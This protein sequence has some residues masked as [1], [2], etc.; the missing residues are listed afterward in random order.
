M[1]ILL[2]G[3]QGQLGWELQRCLAPLGEY[4]A[5][6]FPRVDLGQPDSLRGLLRALCPEVIV[7]AAAYT[8]VDRAEQ[9]PEQAF[10]VNAAA[11]GVL[12][13]E[14]ARLRAVLIHYS[15][16]YVFDGQKG[17]PYTEEEAPNPLNVYG[18]SKWAGEQAVQNAGGA[19]LI[20]R[21]SWVYSLQRDS[22]VTKVLGWARKQQTMRVVTD[23]VAN[24]TWARMLAEL[25][26]QLLAQG[27]K[28]LH[29]WCFE[30]R[31]IYHAA[32]S[33]FTSRYEWGKAVLELDPRREEQ[34]VREYLPAL[35]ADYP[36]PA[37]RPL[38]SALDC[39]RL[40]RTFGLR[41]PD[42]LPALQL[43][44]EAR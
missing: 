6:D 44:M 17:S 22:F 28:D 1:N 18:Q 40:T 32:G 36:T 10:A 38:F 34:V 27:G 25:T 13:E 23:Q 21:T 43:A 26:A 9:E 15:T 20:L 4:T 11:P 42:W 12:A 37:S 16:D 29:D 39:Q 41:L 8:A 30:R 35:T 5:L 33:G 24:P 31:G 3:S 19:S 7:N 2:L 14:A